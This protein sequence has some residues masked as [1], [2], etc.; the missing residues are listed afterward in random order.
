MHYIAVAS[1]TTYACRSG[2]QKSTLFSPKNK[3]LMHRVW[4]DA[5]VPVEFH[6][7]S[8]NFDNIGKNGYVGHLLQCLSPLVMV[9]LAFAFIV[10]SYASAPS[11][12]AIDESPIVIPPKYYIAVGHYIDP[13]L[14]N[15]STA[16]LTDGIDSF[17]YS[18]FPMFGGMLYPRFN[19]SVMGASFTS[20]RYLDIRMTIPRL[21][22]GLELRHL[23][24]IF[25]ISILFPRLGRR[26]SHCLLQLQA[27]SEVEFTT[28]AFLGRMVITQRRLFRD[29]E[30]FARQSTEEYL[31]SNLI[32]NQ[33]HAFTID[34]LQRA[35]DGGAFAISVIQSAQK[36]AKAENEFN[37]TIAIR[38]PELFVNTRASFWNQLKAT[39]VQFFYWFLVAYLIWNTFIE[40]GFRYGVIGAAVRF[41]LRAAKLHAD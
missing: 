13:T 23:N 31:A 37:V 27:E 7:P 38:I 2:F 21:S 9:L 26:M 16:L 35:F 14:Y 20:A 6:G 12:L 22:A 28:M 19:N 17:L 40:M 25:P 24:L 30:P 34:N 1:G 4:R 10:V 18:N 39:Y 15:R 3:R 29:D 41:P 5:A 33:T 36:L 11:T 32:L 8:L